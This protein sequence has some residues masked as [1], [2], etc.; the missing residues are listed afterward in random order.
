MQAQNP[1]TD[2]TT[3]AAD[4]V[5]TIERAPEPR[6]LDVRITIVSYA[7]VDEHC[8]DST[9]GLMGRCIQGMLQGELLNTGSLESIWNDALI[10]RSR[11][12][13]AS[14]LLLPPEQNGGGDV[15]VMIDRDIQYNPDDI[16]ALAHKASAL[17]A[18]VAIPYALRGMPPRSSC[19]MPDDSCHIPHM[20]HDVVLPIKWPGT[21][22]AIP[23]SALER[24]LEWNRT[25]DFTMAG[26]YD[27]QLRTF[28]C[29]DDQAQVGATQFWDF[30]RPLTT[31]L[32][33][34]RYQ[35]LSEEWAFG[36][37][38]IAA[39]VPI[40]AWTK[41]IVSHWGPRAYQLPQGNSPETL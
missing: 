26:W 32:P 5:F 28:C 19:I 16:I 25:L 4:P 10:C 11:S 34:G 27:H 22:H 29:A 6:K 20:G 24:V 33:D 3:P 36:E 17:Q 38:L 13:T 37:R 12:R 21:L 35:Y 41:P 15:C 1:P 7:G 9:I 8:V 18:V 23:R 39:G 31:R 2:A 30:Y 14:K 40:L